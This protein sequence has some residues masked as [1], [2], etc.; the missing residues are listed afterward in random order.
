MNVTFER[1]S[2][3]VTLNVVKTS[4]RD[5]PFRVEPLLSKELEV[6][7]ELDATDAWS[8]TLDLTRSAHDLGAAL[9]AGDEA[10]D[11]RSDCTDSLSTEST[12]LML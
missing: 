7:S 3:S 1:L 11:V 6:S 10:F 12:W 4:E 2:F 9:T 8:G 5:P